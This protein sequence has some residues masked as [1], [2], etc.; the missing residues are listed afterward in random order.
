MSGSKLGTVFWEVL[1]KDDEFRK[2]LA[3]TSDS[4]GKLKS[5]FAN[6]TRG[7]YAVLAGVTAVGASLFKLALA[8]GLDR[9]LNLESAQAQLKAFGYTAD[10]VKGI[11]KNVDTAVTGTI[12]SLD[13]GLTLATTSMASGVKEGANL[14]KYLR[15][16]ADSAT[17][18][19]VSL[20]EM[21]YIFNKVKAKGK[22][23][24]EELAMLTDR[25]IAVLP[26]LGK[27]LGKTTEQMNKMVANGEISA[28]MFEDFMLKKFGG[29]AEA[30]G[31]TTRG[32]F[33]NLKTALARLGATM[34]LPLLDGLKK[35][36]HKLRIFFSDLNA[37]IFKAGGVVNWLKLIWE[38]NQAK[39]L[40][41]AGALAGALLPA[42]ISIL[43]PI[44]AMIAGLV[45][46]VAIGALIGKL[47][48]KIVNH[49][50]GWHK[51][52]DLLKSKFAE[53]QKTL[54]DIY[55]KYGEQLKI[56]AMI[57]LGIYAWNKAYLA[58]KVTTSLLLGK[59]AG[60]IKGMQTFYKVSMYIA[61]MPITIYKSLRSAI[62]SVGKAFT[63]AN[64]KAKAY[65]LGQQMVAIKTTMATVATNGLSVAMLILTSPI[66]WII[67]GI[68]LLVGGLILLYKK[69]ESFR[70][71]VHK[72]WGGFLEL[73]KKVWKGFQD[74]WDIVKPF[75]ED[76]LQ[77]LWKVIQEE[78]M[79]ALKGLWEAL[80]EV[81]DIFAEGAKVIWGI[82]QPALKQ[83]GELWKKYILPALIVV[84]KWVLEFTKKYW[85][86]LAKVLVFVAKIVAGI[87]VVAIVVLVKVIIIVI[88][89]VVWLIKVITAI[90][91][92][93]IPVATAIINF[94]VK[95]FQV[96][97]DV[98][99][100]VAKA[101]KWAWDSVIMPVFKVLWWFIS[102]ILIPIFQLLW[103]VVSIAFAIIWGVIQVAWVI[104]SAIFQLIW[105]YITNVLIPIYQLLWEVIK[106]VFEAIWNVIVWVWNNAIKPVWDLI[107]AYITNILIPIYQKIWEVVKT[108][109]TN[110]WEKIVE[111][112]GW[113]RAVWDAI[114]DYIENTLIPI[115]QKIWD[116]IREVWDKIWDK[117]KTVINWI[118]DK[119]EDAKQAISSLA[120][121]LGEIKD[122][123]VGAFDSAKNW[124]KDKAKDI[125][126][127]LIDGIT[128]MGDKVKE[129]AK[130]IWNNIKDSVVSFFKIGSPSKLMRKYGGWVGEGFNL[131]IQDM[132]ADTAKVMNKMSS[133]VTATIDVVRANTGS[134]NNSID[135][136]TAVDP[137]PVNR[138]VDIGKIEIGVTTKYPPSKKERRE[139]ALDIL[140]EVNDELKSVGED[141]IGNGKLEGET[142]G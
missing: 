61:K 82:L 19:N 113:V 78:L 58:L 90:V 62:T 138:K 135:N 126:Q 33:A 65:A 54:E 107:W 132:I 9:A 31:E 50:G 66:T 5:G 111:I 88:K 27:Q 21:G 116:K 85:P 105:A 77:D 60:L 100:V 93:I 81:W 26:L 68:A 45:P 34:W 112:W 130:R 48:F 117:I 3:G 1:L 55:A 29:S 108:V 20:S 49:L 72:V 24:G 6:A 124:L 129:A 17:A 95:A 127:G 94:M 13:E 139:I 53:F 67:A 128:G 7:S 123:I 102:T 69:N 76:L 46:F 74:G 64:I 84:A 71:L 15:L 63:I 103:S 80:V 106:T 142:N 140:Q 134:L 35:T 141:I 97:W 12:Y 10:Q 52:L 122:K 59:V 22:L 96:L 104:I 120:Q 92:A 73:M 43:A 47:I 86:G 51:A 87:L 91:K 42:L 70:E 30:A 39:I 40:A 32:A 18:S 133:K 121:K 114:W 41:L 56:V 8:P 36:L 109:F 131:G 28:D 119:F 89:V 4:V 37:Q 75:I 57:I 118:K 23:T 11:M 2:G 98:V 44:V 115:F 16:V 99:K 83:L 101:L 110:I 136:R 14:E 25:G 38:Q 79:P 137:V 125:I